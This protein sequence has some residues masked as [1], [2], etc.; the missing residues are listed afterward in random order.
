MSLTPSPP[1]RTLSSSAIRPSAGARV[2]AQQRGSAG[3][4]SRAPGRTGTAGP[5]PRRPGRHA[6]RAS[7]APAVATCSMPSIRFASVGPALRHSGPQQIQCRGRRPCRSNSRSTSRTLAAASSVGSAR[8]LFSVGSRPAAAWPPPRDRRPAWSGRGVR[9][10]PATSSNF[11]TS[12]GQRVTA[13]G[14]QVE[15]RTGLDAPP[16]TEPSHRA[17]R[18]SGRRSPTARPDRRRVRGPARR[19]SRTD[20]SPRPLRSCRMS[21]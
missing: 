8:C 19:P 16:R 10:R 11:S 7:A 20:S 6:R 3:L 17:R 18:G 15:R 2:V 5:R 21:C 9:R 14:A 12:V 4:A 13:R 1:S